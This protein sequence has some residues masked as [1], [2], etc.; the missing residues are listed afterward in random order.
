MRDKDNEQNKCGKIDV[1]N[2]NI[3]FKMTTTRIPFLNV[4]HQNQNEKINEK[5]IEK[6]KS[7]SS[8]VNNSSKQN[9]VEKVK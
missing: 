4:S 9:D 8:V 6:G 3:K 1:V 2:V 5:G 7:D